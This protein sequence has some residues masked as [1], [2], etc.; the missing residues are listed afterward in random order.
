LDL[1]QY[2][3]N[4]PLEAVCAE[5]STVYPQRRK[6][7]GPVETFSGKLAADQPTETVEISTEDYGGV[8]LRFANGA[9]GVMWVS[10]VTA[11][12]KNCLRFE[13]AGSKQSISFN[14]E[15][16]NELWI[17]HRDAANQVLM[18]DPALVGERARGA[19][20]YPGGHNEGFGDTFKQLFR[21]FYRSISNGNFNDP[22]TITFPTFDNGHHEILVCEAILKS[23]RERRWVQIGESIQ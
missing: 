15:S 13:L 21:D 6:P 9:H 10:Q 14:S 19:I 22:E 4:S 1:T 18:R 3:C 7:T 5:L 20:S 11:G 23:H 12:R 8:M 16:P 2:I 17:G